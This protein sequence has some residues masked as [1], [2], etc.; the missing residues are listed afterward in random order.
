LEASSVD[1]CARLCAQ[2]AP[3][4]TEGNRGLRAH[5]ERNDPPTAHRET[6][7]Q[8]VVMGAKFC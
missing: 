6:A 1:L 5:R 4:E 3:A 7:L 8:F 2:D